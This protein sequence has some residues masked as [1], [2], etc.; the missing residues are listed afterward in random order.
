MT[1]ELA[2]L[3][4]YAGKY[5]PECLE[6]TCLDCGACLEGSNENAWEPLLIVSMETVGQKNGVLYDHAHT[7]ARCIASMYLPDEEKEFY[8]SKY[9][10][11]N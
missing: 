3:L 5:F 7:C 9:Q 8:E 4:S 6:S 1:A 10:E 11:E 2:T